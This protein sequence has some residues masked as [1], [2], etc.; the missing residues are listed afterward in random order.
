MLQFFL[1]TLLSIRF[2]D[3]FSDA[4]YKLL[5]R[6]ARYIRSEKKKN[7]VINDHG[8]FAYRRDCCIKF[9]KFF[10]S[11]CDRSFSC[12]NYNVI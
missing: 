6:S 8:S 1:C 9:N 12:D 10:Y 11:Y 2:Y 7:I 3:V 5:V 4:G